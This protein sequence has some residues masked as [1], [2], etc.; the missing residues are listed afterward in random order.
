MQIELNRHPVALN[1]H[2]LDLASGLQPYTGMAVPLG[3][4]RE[5]VHLHEQKR[6]GAESTKLAEIPERGKRGPHLSRTIKKSHNSA[7]N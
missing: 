2:E 4:R 6:G 3:T 1:G 7:S 5:S